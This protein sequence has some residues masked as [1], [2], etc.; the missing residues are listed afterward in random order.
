MKPSFQKLPIQRLQTN[1]GRLVIQTLGK[2]VLE[3]SSVLLRP[4]SKYLFK[5]PEDLLFITKSTIPL[6]HKGD[7][8]EVGNIK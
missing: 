3:D 2:T 5:G 7:T 8:Q 6:V 4:N 1:E